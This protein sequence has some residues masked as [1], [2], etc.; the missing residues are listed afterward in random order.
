MRL[1]KLLWVLLIVCSASALSY[2]QSVPENASYERDITKAV[3]I[4]PNPAV[5]V[6]YLHVKLAQLQASKIKL[7]VHN[8]IGNEM[9]I[10]TEVVDEHELRIKIKDLASGYYLLAIKDDEAKIRKTLKF[11]KRD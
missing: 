2:G 3:H 5:A 8:I 9:A 1:I 4:F 7:T 6:D 10:E 11:L